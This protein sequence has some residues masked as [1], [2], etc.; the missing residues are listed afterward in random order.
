MTREAYNK[1]KAERFGPVS[2]NV[3][4][5]LTA[6]RR[7]ID[8]LDDELARIRD[9]RQAIWDTLISRSAKLSRIS[10]VIDRIGAL[11][12]AAWDPGDE[13]DPDRPP[14]CQECGHSYPCRTA[15]KI[16]RLMT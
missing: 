10:V 14:W 5:D 9:Q 6:A 16:Q 11:H 13:G 15:E 2:D 12:E 8:R 1:I 3:A 4:D 7:E